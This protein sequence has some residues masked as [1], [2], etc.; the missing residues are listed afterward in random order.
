MIVWD[1]AKKLCYIIKFSCPADINIVNKVS[2]KWKIYGPLIRHMQIMHED[3][4]FMFIPIIVRV[5]GQA[6]KCIFTNIQNLGFTKKEIKK[7]FKK[8][9][10]LSVAGT[11]KI[12]KIFM[13]QGQ[14]FNFL[15]SQPNNCLLIFLYLLILPFLTKNSLILNLTVLF[16][17]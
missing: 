13:F 3:Y 9:Q 11:V 8:L 6:P 1:I 14:S 15:D 17:F 2:E 5:S 10:V 4:K 16:G 7:L 12:C